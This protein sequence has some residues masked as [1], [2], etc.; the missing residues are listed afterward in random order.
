MRGRV[1][2][3]APGCQGWTFVHG[4]GSMVSMRDP[5]GPDA[6][7]EL[8]YISREEAA[9]L[10]GVTTAAIRRHEANR[11]IRNRTA[12]GRTLVA[13]EDVEALIGQRD[14]AEMQM[15]QIERLFKARNAA[16]TDY[17][18]LCGEQR[19]E[20]RAARE[21][22]AELEKTVSE[23][24]LR[25]AQALKTFEELATMRHERDLELSEFERS[26]SRKDQALKQFVPLAKTLAAK[27]GLAGKLDPHDELVDALSAIRDSIRPEQQAQLLSVLSPEQG[28][29]L[30]ALF[31]VL[32]K[33]AAL[34]S[35]GGSNGE[36]S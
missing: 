26:Q 13:E 2:L 17:Q 36:Q 18:T 27:W 29:S 3:E 28:A 15:A 10:L 12:N 21:R 5:K 19:T 16:M 33:P 11:K 20:L 32:P 23:M 8:T 35:D 24:H 14:L 1:R 7:R 25:E 4:S 22:I 9:D 31:D 6:E 34:P 30:V